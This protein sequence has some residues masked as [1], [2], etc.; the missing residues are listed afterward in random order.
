MNATK[1][2]SRCSTFGINVQI[3]CFLVFT[4]GLFVQQNSRFM[5]VYT[6]NRK[7]VVAMSLIDVDPH[8]I[9]RPVRVLDE[10]THWPADG[11]HS[12]FEKRRLPYQTRE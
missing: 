7:F 3:H 12:A 4:N 11:N 8:V 6:T 10:G 2:S 1:R 5:I 9:F